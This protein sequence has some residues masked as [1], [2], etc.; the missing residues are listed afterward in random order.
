MAP[1]IHDLGPL[2]DLF[3]DRPEPKHTYDVYIEAEVDLSGFDSIEEIGNGRYR[4][5][6][7]TKAQADTANQINMADV[8]MKCIDVTVS[9][10]HCDQV[11]ATPDIVKDQGI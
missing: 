2:A 9:N 1:D 6:L 11:R 3:G 4:V 7:S 5:V 8:W 10:M